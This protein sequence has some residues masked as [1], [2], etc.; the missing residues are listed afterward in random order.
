MKSASKSKANHENRLTDGVRDLK[1]ILDQLT[2]DVARKTPT[3]LL[4]AILVFLAVLALASCENR[5]ESK[6]SSDED[7]LVSLAAVV[8]QKVVTIEAIGSESQDA[9]TG[10][11]FF[12][13]EDG[14]VATCAH[15]VEGAKSI[16]VKTLS[17]AEFKL[18]SVVSVDSTKDLAILSVATDGAACFDHS[19]PEVS[20]GTRI[21]VLGNPL[22]LR[23]S[24]TDGVVSAIRGGADDVRFLQ[25]SA[26]VSPGSS[27]SP[28]VSLAGDLL[29]MVGA[30]AQGGEGI[31]FALASEEIWAAI[32]QAAAEKDDQ[33]PYREA[34]EMSRRRYLPSRE[35]WD[36]PEW[37]NGSL[38]E[39]TS[40]RLA[41]LRRLSSRYPKVALLRV[42]IAKALRE[43]GEYDQAFE[44]CAALVS[45][46]P[47]NRLAV[48]ELI[49]T[50]T[51][52][53]RKIP[54]VKSAVNADP[55]NFHARRYLFEQEGH[56]DQF[57]S[58]QLSARRALETAPFS[59]R[60]SEGYA[61]A[62]LDH[63]L[64]ELAIR[65]R[66]F[67]SFHG[68]MIR[69]AISDSNELRKLIAAGALML[70]EP[71]EEVLEDFLNIAE[72]NPARALP[73]A[74]ELAQLGRQGKEEVKAAISGPIGE[75]LQSF[76]REAIKNEPLIAEAY[77][78]E[79]GAVDVREG[80]LI[81]AVG[82][83]YTRFSPS[84]GVEAPFDQAGMLFLLAD[85]EAD[86]ESES[87]ITSPE[88]VVQWF[89]TLKAYSESGK[90]LGRIMPRISNR[91][92]GEWREPLV[93]QFWLAT[94]KRRLGEQLKAEGIPEGEKAEL[95]AV[96]IALKGVPSTS[97]AERAV[98]AVMSE[99]Q[100]SIWEYFG[101]EY[102]RPLERAFEAAAAK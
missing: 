86:G 38:P 29:G 22:G 79:P 56:D 63:E 82:S 89:E 5:T 93:F 68:E 10:S 96:V 64:H 100:L 43:D 90:A 35:L 32:N 97:D 17:G 91:G 18:M 98:R 39:A 36:D 72:E 33:A 12:V 81:D 60:I 70:A 65:D 28:V 14:K 57:L 88:A 41:V 1:P 51:K 47:G 62:L 16:R 94:Q 77:L 59:L 46:D 13:T 78:L 9:Q 80:L 34:L 87:S 8:S 11:G 40:Q 99:R 3:F 44:E 30:R 102:R 55:L 83:G 84:F 45:Q 74:W 21:A 92:K 6:S 52:E 101:R 42:E 37:E 27:G 15:L 7:A 48:S 4:P 67:E 24:L 49:G 66:P 53:E 25:I 58:A 20:V 50:I 19:G 76:V 85:H 71:S 61:E 69:N 26:P 23:G 73:Y 95:E 2:S 75:R 31:G 54:F